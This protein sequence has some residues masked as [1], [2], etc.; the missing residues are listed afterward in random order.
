VW[1][2]YESDSRASRRSQELTLLNQVVDVPVDSLID[3]LQVTGLE[4]PDLAPNDRLCVRDPLGFG[5]L[6]FATGDCFVE[7][8]RSRVVELIWNEMT[9]D[10]RD[11]Q[12]VLRHVRGV[13]KRGQEASPVRVASPV[14]HCVRQGSA[15]AK[16]GFGFVCG[17]GWVWDPN[18]MLFSKGSKTYQCELTFKKTT[19]FLAATAMVVGLCLALVL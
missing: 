1:V 14:H 18:P 9:R 3:D 4:L 5:L 2:V 15:R 6:P 7:T 19:A 11:W 17:F 12:Y 13:G 10:C 8:L 16:A